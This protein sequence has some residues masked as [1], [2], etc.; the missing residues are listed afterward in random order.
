MAEWGRIGAID[1][2]P[3]MRGDAMVATFILHALLL[4]FLMSLRSPVLPEPDITLV[5]VDIVAITPAP[6]ERIK[7]QAAFAKPKPKESKSKPAP[8]PKLPDIVPPPVAPIAETPPIS[9]APSELI[10]SRAAEAGEA[11]AAP[12]APPDT[13]GDYAGSRW[14]L[15][16]PLS[17]DNLKENWASDIEC[18]QSLSEDCADIRK[19]V[20][21]EYQLTDT[22][23]VWTER[24]ADTGMPSEFYGLSERDIRVKLRMNIAGENGFAILPGIGIDGELWDKLHGVKKGCKMTRGIDSTGAYNVVRKCPDSL[25]SARDRKYYIPPKE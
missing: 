13:G 6:V 16:P 5:P 3:R 24:R 19:E 8:R 20:F 14:A 12:S 4:A 22:E 1:A 2:V 18:L 21:A 7:P 15:T 25:P 23:K 11:A 10:T 9:A 17:A